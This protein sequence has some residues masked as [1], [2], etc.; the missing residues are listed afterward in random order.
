MARIRILH[1]LII[2]GF[3]LL[4]LVLAYFQVVKFSEYQQLSQANRIRILPQP[5]SRGRIFDRNGNVLADNTLSYNVLILPQETE[6]VE[7][8]ILKLSQILLIPPEQLNLRFKKGYTAPFIPILICEDISFDKAIAIGQLKY[9]LPQVVI[10]TV[11]KRSYPFANVISHVLGYIRQIDVWRLERLKEYG[12]KVQDLIGYSGIEEVYDYVLRPHKGGMQVE[13]DNKGRL[14]RIIGFKPA[15]KGK[16]IQLTI[17]LRLQK[18]VHRNLKG[19]IG[20]VIIL[21]PFT[22]EVFALVSSPDFNPQVFLDPPSKSVNSLLRDPDAPLL[23]RAVNASYPLG[24]VFKL[25][26]AAAGLEEK[27]IDTGT[28]F[29]CSGGTQI[30]NRKFACWGLH[31]RE[32]IFAAITHSCNVFFYKLGLRLGPQLITE[33][34]LKFGFGQATGIDLSS[35][36]AGDVPYSLWDRIKKRQF[37]FDGDTANLSI[38]QGELLVVPLQVARMMAAFA[39]GGKLVTPR[40]IKSINNG[41]QVLDLSSSTRSVNLSIDKETLEII[42]SGM[43]GVVND[44]EG[45]ANILRGLG[46]NVAG[47]TGTAQVGAGQAHAWFTG[48]F[49]VKQPKFVICVFLEH[50]GSSLHSVELTREIIKE[51]LREGLL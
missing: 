33:Y 35:E 3:I 22:G 50:A 12:Y 36:S 1:N 17:D 32:D 2:A 14:S 15:E 24:S 46:I 18:I 39:N 8:Q 10:Q 47:K 45:S 51:M 34:A 48:Y 19:K 13:V 40:L 28:V 6:Y 43:A 26:V 27:K 20:S 41:N 42:K 29:F 38:G 30:G 21:D 11:P 23:N 4:C 49:P 16:D 44:P 37:W 5:A 9:D 7:E 31:A 25:V